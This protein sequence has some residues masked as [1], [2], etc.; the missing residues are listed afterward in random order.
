MSLFDK[1]KRAL[2]ALFE[3]YKAGGEG[4]LSAHFVRLAQDFD[5]CP[6]F[7]TKKE[8][9]S[10]FKESARA[11]EG[12]VGDRDAC[13]YAGFVE[14]LGRMAL[15]ALSKPAFAHIYPTTRCEGRFARWP[16]LTVGVLGAEKRCG[17]CWRCGA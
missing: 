2:F 13:S 15:V 14:A 9:R 17:C 1:Y 16:A 6:T 7:L 12:E 5:I 8:L 11:H 10:I 4:L 3:F